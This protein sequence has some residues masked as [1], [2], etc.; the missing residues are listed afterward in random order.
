[1]IEF[2]SDLVYLIH[3]LSAQVPRAKRTRKKAGT[4]EDET[5]GEGTHEAGNK[6]RPQRTSR[7]VTRS[8][9]DG[10][11]DE[12]TGDEGEAP[13]PITPKAKPRPRP[14][15][16]QKTPPEIS[17][18]AEN[19]APEPS[20]N[21]AS[22]STVHEP[23]AEQLITSTPQ[24]SRKRPRSEEPDEEMSPAPDGRE[25]VSGSPGGPEIEVRRKRVRH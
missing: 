4:G 2:I 14:L 15:L 20:L 6:V 13:A 3:I 25:S 8:N 17:A 11:L 10:G 21:P 12:S 19:M 9:P 5:D 22:P 1:M 24:S 23:E 18:A 16:R 7:R